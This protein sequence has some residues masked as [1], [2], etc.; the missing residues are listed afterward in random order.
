VRSFSIDSGITGGD[1]AEENVSF[2]DFA[3][4]CRASF[5][6]DPLI[7]AF[8]NHAVPFQVVGTDPQFSQ[9]PY[10]GAVRT[11]KKIYYSRTDASITAGVTADILEMIDKRDT[12]S[13]VLKFIMV[14]RDAGEDALKRIALFSDQYGSD[15]H[16]FFR[17]LAIRQGFDDRDERA[18]AVS[19][20]TLHASKGLEFNTVFI[21]GCERG[22]IPFELFGKKDGTELSEEE[23]LFYVGVTRTVKNLYL[24]HAKRRAVKGRV[25]I[26]ERSPLLDRLEENLLLKGKREPGKPKKD[27]SQLELFK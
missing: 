20:M 26:Q 2:S 7:E 3:V 10:R 5:M 9:E 23:R 14:V 18:E 15:Y 16:E 12:V 13:D 4:L 8:R 21:P 22:I 11:L 25:M 27:T 6:F 19:I 1:A 24:T 17:S